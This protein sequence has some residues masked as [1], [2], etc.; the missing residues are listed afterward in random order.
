M[1]D[2]SRKKEELSINHGF[3]K[4]TKNGIRN[5]LTDGVV[6]YN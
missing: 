3:L 2:G 4:E 6:F 5:K 1:D